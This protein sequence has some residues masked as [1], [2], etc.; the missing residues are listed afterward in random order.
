MIEQ[1]TLGPTTCHFLTRDTFD[2]I[3]AGWLTQNHLHHIVTLNPEMVMA[4]ATNHA[5]A[6]A[7]NN[8]TL[9]VPDGAG[10]IWARWYL[11]SSYWSLWPS[12]VAFPGVAAERLTGINVIARLSRLAAA[13]G[14]SVYLLGGTPQQNRKT[15]RLLQKN[16]PSLTVYTGPDHTYDLTGPVA[17]L[18]DINLKRPDI[19]FVAYGAPKQ[20]LWINQ[21]RKNLPSV[22]IAVG[23]GGAFAILSED[24]P[25]APRW[26]RQHNLEWLW[27]LILEPSRA[28]RIY[29]A[30]IKFP[31]LIHQQKL[32]R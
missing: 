4:A 31:L 23:V 16:H 11:R 19:L 5:F 32:D 17:V 14:K 25:R 26:L 2:R 1:V 3:A 30:T 27:R 24:K 20:S 29:T 6:A 9:R 13:Q 15:A 7:I 22:K 21:H 28:K 10:I 12:L 18:A 8:A